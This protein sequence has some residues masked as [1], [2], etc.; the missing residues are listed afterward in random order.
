M[1]IAWYQFRE[2][3]WLRK[4]GDAAFGARFESL[5]DEEA[6]DLRELY[7]ELDELGL[8]DGLLFADN[9]VWCAR[10]TAKGKRESSIPR[11]AAGI[12]QN[13]AGFAASVLRGFLSGSACMALA[14][15]MAHANAIVSAFQ[16][17]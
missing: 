8:V 5:A 17:M 16:A 12:A 14:G 11:L 15:A 7:G 4:N 10:L 1:S 6:A 13:A 9:R 3:R 2:L